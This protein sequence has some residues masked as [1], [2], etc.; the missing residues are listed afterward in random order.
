MFLP[1]RDQ[2]I[3]QDLDRMCDNFSQIFA[4]I[5]IAP[6]TIAYY[7][8][9]SVERSDTNISANVISNMS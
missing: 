6:F 9:K 2:R 1:V 7:L 5:I 4:P 8:Y 3:T